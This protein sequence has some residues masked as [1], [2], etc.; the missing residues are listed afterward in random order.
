M[1]R[2]SRVLKLG[3]KATLTFGKM[4][5]AFLV[6]LLVSSGCRSGQTAVEELAI[7]DKPGLLSGPLLTVLVWVEPDKLLACGS[8]S[9]NVVLYRIRDRRVERILTERKEW[10]QSIAHSGD[11]ELLAASGGINDRTVTVWRTRDWHVVQKLTAPERVSSVTF[12]KN[13]DYLAA[14]GSGVSGVLVWDTKK[15]A[16]RRLRPG[17]NLVSYEYLRAIPGAQTVAAMRA[18]SKGVDLIDVSNGHRRE[19]RITTP[20]DNRL[21]TFGYN[22]N[23]RVLAI[24]AGTEGVRLFN[25]S[26][27]EIQPSLR[28]R[29]QDGLDAVEFSPDGRVLLCKDSWRGIRLYKYPSLQQ[30]ASL[31]I[32]PSHQSVPLFSTDAEYVY[33]PYF[34]TLRQWRPRSPR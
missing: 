25:L 32:E 9:G 16:L 34:A 26:G 2:L 30:Y 12:L 10:I 8:T 7:A 21:H 15:W 33:V 5:S 13:G 6:A 28:M 31:D 1:R 11:R 4:T 18:D 22:Q 20:T 27:K 17:G 3:D 19:L 29:S 24:P 14:V 23:A